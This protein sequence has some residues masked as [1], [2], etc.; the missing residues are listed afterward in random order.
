MVNDDWPDRD[1]VVPSTLT[2]KRPAEG[3]VVP[4]RENAVPMNLVATRSPFFLDKCDVPAFEIF[5]NDQAPLKLMTCSGRG[6]DIIGRLE[7]SLTGIDVTINLS[8]AMNES[9]ILGLVVR[10]VRVIVWLA[11]GRSVC[12]ASVSPCGDRT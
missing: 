1:V 10:L 6:F 5:W 4:R 7:L 3:E 11:S 9:G 2:M 8:K 12:F